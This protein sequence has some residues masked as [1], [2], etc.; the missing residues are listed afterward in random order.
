[1]LSKFL[2]ISLLLCSAAYS[3]EIDKEK[4]HKML[5]EEIWKI[6]SFKKLL[7][8]SSDIYTYYY[9]MGK[10]A[11]IMEARR[12]IEECEVRLLLSQQSTPSHH[13]Y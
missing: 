12:A 8:D 5:D 4:F 11:A 2:V 13:P 10:E 6:E 7:T 9:M 1:M 3:A